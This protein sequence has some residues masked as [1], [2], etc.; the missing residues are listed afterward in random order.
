MANWFAAAL[1]LTRAQLLGWLVA[2]LLAAFV[3]GGVIGW[4]AG[5]AQGRADAAEARQSVAETQLQGERQLRNQEASAASAAA[6]VASASASRHA[7]VEIH[8]QTIEKEVIRYVQ[9]PAAAIE[10]L[11]A[12]GLRI[13]RAA[14]RG[15][16]ADSQPAS[17]G[18]AAMP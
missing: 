8:Y 7:R 1:S 6:V 13:W 9:T 11:D 14:N 2:A 10:C 17:T 16:F 3:A 5:S 12:D 18:H 15:E 4:R